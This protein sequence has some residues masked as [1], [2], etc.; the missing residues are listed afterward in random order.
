MEFG[1]KMDAARV[2]EIS[3]LYN[4]EKTMRIGLGFDHVRSKN[5]TGSQFLDHSV[6]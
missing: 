1:G 2:L 6:Y 5:E 3:T 4:S